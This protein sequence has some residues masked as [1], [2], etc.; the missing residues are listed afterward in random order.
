MAFKPE[1]VPWVSLLL[2]FVAFSHAQELNC[3][4]IPNNA[5][6]VED[7]WCNT[8]CFAPGASDLP[9]NLAIFCSELAGTQ[10]VCKCSLPPVDCVGSLDSFTDCSESCGGGT[11]TAE[12]TITT[13]AQY[14][15]KECFYANNEVVARSCNLQSC[16]TKGFQCQALPHTGATDAW[17][18]LNCWPPGLDG[19]LRTF[20]NAHPGC[21]TVGGKSQVC[22]CNLI[23]SPSV[24]C[25]ALPLK[26]ATGD[27]C[28]KNC[29]VPGMDRTLENVISTCTAAGAEH[30]VCFCDQ[31]G[32]E[33]G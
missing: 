6:H 18:G 16:P 33:A 8:S 24:Q 1:I 5:A 17:C 23:V 2:T 9:L 19:T 31:F 4:A 3:T 15:G 26:G 7:L 27:W 13:P 14:G 22:I 20:A 11:Q 32:P 29:W 21:T 30:Q 25:L 10:Q 12:F 28:D